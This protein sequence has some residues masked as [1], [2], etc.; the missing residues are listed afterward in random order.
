MKENDFCELPLTASTL[1]P[2]GSHLSPYLRFGCLS[3]RL[4]YQ[5]MTEEYIKVHIKSFNNPVMWSA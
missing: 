3:P 1:M 5:R 2:S 4:L